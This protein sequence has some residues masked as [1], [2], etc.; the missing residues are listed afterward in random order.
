M[1]FSP[2]TADDDDDDDRND[3]YNDEDDEVFSPSRK[4]GR[5]MILGGVFLVVLII[6]IVL[7]VV[8]SRNDKN[9]GL[10]STSSAAR[11]SNGDLQFYNGTLSENSVSNIGYYHCL[12]P[13]S[14]VG[15]DIVLLHGGAFSKEEWK[16][17]GIMD[18]FCGR[19]FTAIALDLPTST[20]SEQLYDLLHEMAVAQL[21]RLPVT[22]VTPSASGWAIV[23]WIRGTSI[24]HLLDDVVSTWVPVAVGTLNV[25]SD[26]EISVLRD[27]NLRVLAIYGDEDTSGG[28][29]SNKLGE[30]V[31][32]TV[33][34]LKGGH[35]VY[36]NSPDKFVQ[37][38]VDFLSD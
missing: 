33:V 12:S 24:L 8:L 3:T 25:L 31:G 5:G 34:E 30:L 13:S 38:I 15:S 2:P 9:N 32:A 35:P 27:Q 16:T 10:T 4:R 21:I 1:K 22:L 28:E 7:A 6:V 36:L 19:S 26:K 23:D 20:N 29:L 14:P 18:D 11:E 17:T 37:T